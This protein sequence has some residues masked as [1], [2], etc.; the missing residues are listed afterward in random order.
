MLVSIN[1][2]THGNDFDVRHLLDD[3]N[4]PGGI[5]QRDGVHP[6]LATKPHWLAIGQF[7]HG[8][9]RV[10]QLAVHLHLVGI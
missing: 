9:E 8:V 2:K 7:G 10:E 5:P 4:A 6:L 1:G 3:L